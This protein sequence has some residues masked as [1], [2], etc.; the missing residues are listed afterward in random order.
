[1]NSKWSRSKTSQFLAAGAAYIIPSTIHAGAWLW[2]SAACAVAVWMALD[3][4]LAALRGE[5]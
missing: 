1:M 5:Q 3:T 4:I 2:M